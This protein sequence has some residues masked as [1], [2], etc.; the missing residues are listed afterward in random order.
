M[1]RESLELVEQRSREG[2][3]A[4][5]RRAVQQQP[6]LARERAVEEL[7]RGG[8]ERSRSGRAGQRRRTVTG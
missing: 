6:G 4:A 8:C 7:E 2:R 1:N 3:L 5:A